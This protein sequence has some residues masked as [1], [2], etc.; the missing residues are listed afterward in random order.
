MYGL[1]VGQLAA[2]WRV[3]RVQGDAGISLDDVRRGMW[4]CWWWWGGSWL[5]LVHN[6]CGP[7]T[8]AAELWPQLKRLP[9][10]QAAGSTT[11]THCALPRSPSCA[12]CR[13]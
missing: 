1:W 4:D 3:A 13:C 9:L 11:A 10:K 8:Q 5:L 7:L 2:A 6:A 12:P